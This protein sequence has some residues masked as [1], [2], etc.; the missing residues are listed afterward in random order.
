MIRETL[1]FRKYSNQTDEFINYLGKIYD[2]SPYR[3]IIG[4]YAQ[5]IHGLMVSGN[6]CFKT[7]Q[8]RYD[9]V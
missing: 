6:L 8:I 1:I 4:H 3:A 7:H 2:C 9:S 5:Y